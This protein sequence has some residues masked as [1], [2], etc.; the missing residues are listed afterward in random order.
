MAL[1]QQLKTARMTDATA[2]NTID[3]EVGNLEQAI[4]DILGAPVNTNI[5]AKLFDIVAAGLRKIILRDLAGDPVAIGELARNGAVLKF[6]DGVAVRTFLTD[7][8]EA[9]TDPHTGY[10]KESEKSAANGYASLG[11]G[12]LVPIAE[13]ASGT[14]TGSK[15]IRDDG[16]LQVPS[17]T[18]PAASVGT[19]ELKTA[20]G[21]ATGSAST[22]I[23]MNDYSFA[24]NVHATG[25]GANTFAVRAQTTLSTGT[26]G[27]FRMEEVG[28]G[29]SFTVR[30][31]Y[32]TASRP[33]EIVILRKISTGEIVAVWKSQIDDPQRSPLSGNGSV[34]IEKIEITKFPDR[35]FS[36]RVHADKILKDLNAG[37]LSLGTTIFRG[38]I[39][40]AII[41]AGVRVGK[42]VGTETI[43]ASMNPLIVEAIRRGRV[44]FRGASLGELK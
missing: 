37:A 34:D 27:R 10:Q 16:T 41:P 35:L 32:V 14:P 18:P 25:V 40:K 13:L 17:S 26:V 15:F 42:T 12:V 31:R 39:V 20:T 28:S 1:P 11:A 44:I 8:H 6:H 5:T 38:G 22:D 3:N 33:G 24:P 7:L 30:W 23:A 21:S 9:A 4:A 43:K 19:T 2:G 29:E 36:D